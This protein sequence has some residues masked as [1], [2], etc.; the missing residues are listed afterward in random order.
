MLHWT[1][2]NQLLELPLLALV[3]FDLF[4][5]I[6]KSAFVSEIREPEKQCCVTLVIIFKALNLPMSCGNHTK[7]GFNQPNDVNVLFTIL[8]AL[9]IS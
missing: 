9:K 6:Y 7:N 1:D 4:K 3:N 2:K 5:K 8:S